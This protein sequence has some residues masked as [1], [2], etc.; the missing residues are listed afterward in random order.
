[1]FTKIVVCSDGSEPALQASRIA[2]EIA[3]RFHAELTLL[4]VYNP[5]G[6]LASFAMAPEA[7]PSNDI[8]MSIGEE[9][10]KVV[11]QKT[12]AILDR[13]GVTY[14]FRGEMGHPV[15][16]INDVAEGIGADLIVLGSRGMSEWKALLLGS[17]SDGVLHHA[18][19]PVLIVRGEQTTFTKILLAC[20]GSAG[21]FQATRSAGAL[22]D[23]FGAPLVILN[24]LEPLSALAQALQ[25]DSESSLLRARQLIGTRVRGMAHD[26]DCAF[27]MQQEVGHPA[28]TIVQIARENDY[29][30]IVVGSRGMSALKALALGSVSNRV[31]HHSH[32]SVL[33]VR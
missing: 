20:D 33:V 11:Q 14:Q 10:H 21:A 8:V 24:V 19:C 31:A 26:V 16:C 4:S 15:D 28:E 1:M 13:A 6:V 32:C 27:T 2:A 9:T 12:G 7:A 25:P 17:V 18:H 5:A 22:A 30:L 23:K 29:P 3:G